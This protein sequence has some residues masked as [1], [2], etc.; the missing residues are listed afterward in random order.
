MSS[1]FLQEKTRAI[2]RALLSTGTEPPK[3][4]SDTY[5]SDWENLVNTKMPYNKVSFIQ[6]KMTT[7]ATVYTRDI[8]LKNLDSASILYDVGHMKDGNIGQKEMETDLDSFRE[9]HDNV[10]SSQMIS[11][12]ALFCVQV[13]KNNGL[14][15]KMDMRLRFSTEEGLRGRERLW[16]LRPSVSE[17]S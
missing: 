15:L 10:R 2:I 14:I 17:V 11:S 3:N 7:I 12:H 8:N 1:V 16:Y 4:M 13:R 6:D 9:E 5:R